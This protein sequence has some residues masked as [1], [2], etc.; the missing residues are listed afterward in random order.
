MTVSNRGLMSSLRPIRMTRP[1]IAYMQR[2]F[3]KA[4]TLTG[5]E[6]GRAVPP[7]CMPSLNQGD[8]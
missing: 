5:Q 2:R 4:L 7:E 3:N 1:A 8:P 6:M